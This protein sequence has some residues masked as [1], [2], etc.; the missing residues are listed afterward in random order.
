[1]E[2]GKGK[3]CSEGGV[4]C[5]STELNPEVNPVATESKLAS[6]STPSHY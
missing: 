5:M 3:T 1:M 6:Q 4:N 2:A